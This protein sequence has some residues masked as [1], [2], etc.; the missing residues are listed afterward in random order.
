MLLMLAFACFFVMFAAW[1]LVPN[2]NEQAATKPA[3]ESVTSG[4]ST[5][6]TQV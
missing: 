4:A 3:P 1:L 2:V 5:L 6:Q